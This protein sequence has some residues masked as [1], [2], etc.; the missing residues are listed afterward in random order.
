VHVMYAGKVVEAG[1]AEQVFY[2]SGMPYTKGLLGSLPRLDSD[3]SERLRPI[4]GTPPVMVGLPSGCPFAPRCPLRQQIC[5]E[6]EPELRPVGAPVRDAAG[7]LHEAACHF[8]KDVFE[9]TAGPIFE[10]TSVDLEASG[11]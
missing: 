8:A 5:L 11:V 6:E 2:T 1:T 7:R 9:G 3:A 10:P 4:P